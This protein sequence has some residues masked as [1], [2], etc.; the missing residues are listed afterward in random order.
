MIAKECKS[1]ETV[2]LYVDCH[3]KPLGTLQKIHAT[4]YELPTSKNFV[5]IHLPLT[6]FIMTSLTLPNM[7]NP[8]IPAPLARTSG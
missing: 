1:R 4:F 2:N 5:F 6:N 8:F 7:F 3:V